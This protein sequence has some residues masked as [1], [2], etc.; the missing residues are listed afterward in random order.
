LDNLEKIYQEVATEMGLSKKDVRSIAESQFVFVAD[1]MREKEL[2]DV[3]LQFFGLFKVKPGRLQHLS[4]NS[5]EIIKSKT[6]EFD[7][8]L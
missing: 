5:K 3:R 7:K 6:N 4:K 2:K 8:I 1:T